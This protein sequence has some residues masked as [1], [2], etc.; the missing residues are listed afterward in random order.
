[1]PGSS[2]ASILT[3]VGTAPLDATLPELSAAQ[4]DALQLQVTNLADFLREQE[5]VPDELIE[6]LR[7]DSA[8]TRAAAAIAL[9]CQH[10]FDFDHEA[11]LDDL[12][13]MTAALA[14]PVP[15]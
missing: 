8:G 4:R 10:I 11:A 14:Q 15:A 13:R 12:E 6:A 2:A 1:V 3:V 7:R 9:L 5:L